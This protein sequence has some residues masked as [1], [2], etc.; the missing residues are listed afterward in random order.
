VEIHTAPGRTVFELVLP[1]D[2]PE[3]GSV[4]T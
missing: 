4:F 2:T 1:T 3:P